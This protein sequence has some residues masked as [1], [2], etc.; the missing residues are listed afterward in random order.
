MNDK[1]IVGLYFERDEEAIRQT[2]LKYGVR[3]R[4]IAQ[5]I[6]NDHDDAMECEN[7]TY[8][9]AWRLIPPNDPSEYLFPFLAKITRHLCLD[10]CRK[11]H[12]K[13]R[14]VQYIELSKELE[15]CL[16]APNDAEEYADYKE[17]CRI[18]NHFLYSQTDEKRFI[19]IRRYWSMESIAEIAE[20]A[21]VSESK[22]KTALHRSRKELKLRLQKEGYAL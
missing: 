11:R 22:V 15:E 6:L 19:F 12:S 3:I 13:K 7:D 16:P 9:Q 8:I 5:G 10:V 14:Y 20:K 21:G 4:N 2:S 18:I 1:Q 17:L